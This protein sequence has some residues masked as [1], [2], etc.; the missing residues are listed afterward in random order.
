MVRQVDNFDLRGAFNYLVEDQDEGGMGL[1]RPQAESQIAQRLAKETAFDYT[2]ATEAGFNNQQIISKLTGI[3]DRGALSTTAEGFTRGAI[4][5]VPAALTMK[6]GWKRG[7]QLGAKVPGTL[8]VKAASTLLGG[9]AGAVVLPIA[10][11]L[12][13]QYV[14]VTKSAG[15]FLLGEEEPV[16]P[17]DQPFREAG[18]IGGA[19]LTFSGAL[20]R[21]LA[22]TTFGDIP[23]DAGATLVGKSADFGSKKLLANLR[24][25]DPDAKVPLSLRALRGTEDI[26]TRMATRARGSKRD[27]YLRQEIPIAGGAG[28]GAAIA[29]QVD[30]GDA[31]TSFFATLGGALLTPITPLTKLASGA[32]AKSAQAG[33]ALRH[34]VETL[35]S[36]SFNLKNKAE[37][38]ARND[39]IKIYDE[40]AK[41]LEAPGRARAAAENVPYNPAVHSPEVDFT[42][43][44]PAGA[45]NLMQTARETYGA[46][47]PGIEETFTPGTTIID[48]KTPGFEAML[49]I[50]RLQAEAMAKDPNL[51]T[52][53]SNSTQEAV[54][55]GYRM[56]QDSIEVKA[57]P[58]VIAAHTESYL[59]EQEQFIGEFL[60]NKFRKISET[61][62]K[63]EAKGTLEPGEGS[64][65]IVREID[66]L[67][68]IA[69]D[70]EKRLFSPELIDYPAALKPNNMIKVL[71]EVENMAQ[72]TGRLGPGDITS[73]E[74]KQVLKLIEEITARIPKADPTLQRPPK[75]T[76]KAK[77]KSVAIPAVLKPGK[78]PFVNR[79]RSLVKDIDPNFGEME[80]LIAA[81]G[82]DAIVSRR[83]GSYGQRIGKEMLPSHRM[84]RDG[85][86][87]LDGLIEKA[88]EAGYFPGEATETIGHVEILAAI[89]KNVVLPDD[90]AKLAEYES[91]VETANYFEQVLEKAGI[92]SRSKTSVIR[93]MADNELA[94]Y[95]YEIESGMLPPKEIREQVGGFPKDMPAKERRRLVKE[96]EAQAQ[97]QTNQIQYDPDIP[98]QIMTVGD[99][100]RI[101]SLIGERVREL[102]K[103][104][105]GR[106]EQRIL[107]LLDKAILKDLSDPALTEP[108]EALVI[109]NTFTKA[110]NDVFSRTLGGEMANKLK[111]SDPN[112]FIENLLAAGRPNELGNR[113]T[114][115]QK[116]GSFF[117]DQATALKNVDDPALTELIERTIPVSKNSAKTIENSM[118][119]VIRGMLI[120][121]VI[122]PK[123]QSTL[124][125]SDIKKALPG[126]FEADQLVVNTTRLERFK[127]KYEV[128]ADQNPMI[129][130]LFDDM[131]DPVAAQKVLKSLKGGAG[132]PATNTVVGFDRQ[133]P[134]EYKTLVEAN[135]NVFK[136]FKGEPRFYYTQFLDLRGTKN[137]YSVDFGPE[138]LS[139]LFPYTSFN[140]NLKAEPGQALTF[141][142]I[143]K[144]NKSDLYGVGAWLQR[145]GIEHMFTGAGGA[146]NFSEATGII[147][148]MQIGDLY[149]ATMAFGQRPFGNSPFTFFSRLR[150]KVNKPN[151]SFYFNRK[152]DR[153]E[154][155]EAFNNMSERGKKA[156]ADYE[157]A[158]LVLPVFN[159]PQRMARDFNVAL[160]RGDIAKL[161]EVT[162]YFNK[163]A[164]N[165]KAMDKLLKEVERIDVKEI[166]IPSNVAFEATI[167]DMAKYGDLQYAYRQQAIPTMQ[168]RIAQKNALS[169]ILGV[170]SPTYAITQ[171]LESRQPQTKL[172]T[173]IKQVNLMKTS[174]IPVMYEG[175]KVPAKDV[176]K[177]AANGLL[178][179]FI[180]VARE[181]SYVPKKEIYG[182]G[183]E[184]V[185]FYDAK[186]FR[187]F[188]FDT[189]KVFPAME[190][191]PPLADTLLK[192]KIISK[193]KYKQI[194]D[195]TEGL[196]RMQNQQ[197]FMERLPAMA[198]EKPNVLKR[199]ATRFFGAQVGS[200]LGTMAGGRGTIQIP[201]FAAGVAEDLL[202]KSPNT[203]FISYM[204]ELFQPGGYQKLEEILEATAEESIKRQ[205]GIDYGFRRT[206]LLDSPLAPA[207]PVEAITRDREEEREITPPPPRLISQ[208]SP[209]VNPMQTAN[210]RARYAAMFPFDPAS[211]VV[212]ER[213]AQG[214]GSLPRP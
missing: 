67:R 14:G 38:K 168:E 176:Y 19:F 55:L 150:E 138:E 44:T 198:E 112:V 199:F 133:K 210:Q 85:E 182:T 141:E 36:I 173:L 77:R 81:M 43:I 214:I 59:K 103:D 94:N 139:R 65:I 162:N 136:K 6:E 132:L 179:S 20:R 146:S 172:N 27:Y 130:E 58:T 3:E 181:A 99:A 187:D 72:L 190:D 191:L 78:E 76:T 92:D 154:Y 1:T 114:G 53:V 93:G 113:I 204:G 158:S 186:I 122:E 147:N 169:D 28:V 42:S 164:T 126:E 100:I 115:L 157:K 124:V 54:S 201:G 106:S 86:T 2:A 62:D 95:V 184:P 145:S 166:L 98:A 37:S 25:Y 5:A 194:K 13:D 171:I 41:N 105:K 116:F 127:K 26:A 91:K 109:A 161:E 151:V 4:G 207:F 180:Q 16:L 209:S 159:K 24:K 80:E 110:K 34:P 45:A 128:A 195:V 163:A 68:D 51:K 183:T 33:Q 178:N 61:L 140:K 160:A 11:S 23:M 57:P 71:N 153:D 40:L 82:E 7:V 60:H 83:L 213:Q 119:E 212:R 174:N 63:A 118:V 32:A 9:V 206:P 17:S 69:R 149:G 156:A 29:E 175:A 125:P 75:A 192:Q 189:G 208:A 79:I 117:E 165:E 155:L 144:Y 18:K 142:F 10:A 90:A 66:K 177:P 107:K 104:D 35:K 74:G 111:Y 143:Q 102:A 8:P 88:I 152:V 202:S 73:K 22:K 84:R 137:N 47:I 134:F 205:R 211:A 203:F 188:F 148:P 64:K 87:S 123:P 197:M 39:L 170:D 131:S 30:P 167:K 121:G 185:S 120:N 46:L 70:I 135:P 49:P 52:S 50:F 97:A 101:R 196:E 96:Q 31:V 129:K 12:V 193:A 21:G 108:A 15:D 89:E 48:P 56:L 200:R